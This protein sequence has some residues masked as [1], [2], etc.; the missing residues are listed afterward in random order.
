[1]IGREKNWQ[2]ESSIRPILRA[3]FIN[4]RLLENDV[5]CLM[6]R[7]I[8]HVLREHVDHTEST[9]PARWIVLIPCIIMKVL[10]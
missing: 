7:L 6:L 9:A 5:K 1:M 4:F 2:F 8:P 10:S 3:N